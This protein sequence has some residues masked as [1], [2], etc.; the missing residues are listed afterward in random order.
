MSSNVVPL[1]LQGTSDISKISTDLKSV[2]T[3]S[4]NAAT[5]L[6]SATTELDK[7]SKTAQTF[8][9]KLKSF[10]SNFGQLTASVAGLGGSVLNLSRQY[11]DLG[12]SQIKVDQK[13]LKL[14]KSTE[15]VKTA[16]AKLQDLIRKGIKSGAAYEQAQLDVTQALEQET[17]AQTLLGEAV[18]DQQRAQENFWIGLVPTITTAGGTIMGIL[19]NMSGMKGFGG[20]KSA[21]ESATVAIGGGGGKGGG[22]GAGLL[23]ALGMI[24]GGTLA[25]ITGGAAG[26]GLILGQAEQA[27][28]GAAASGLFADPLKDYNKNLKQTEIFMKA[29]NATAFEMLFTFEAVRQKFLATNPV[30][31]STGQILVNMKSQ[32]SDLGPAFAETSAQW[33]GHMANYLKAGESLE[34]IRTRLS[35]AGIKEADGLKIITQ[36]YDIYNTS[37]TQAG[38]ATDSYAS[39]AQFLNANLQPMGPLFDQMTNSLTQAN[40]SLAASGSGLSNLQAGLNAGTA[41]GAA[42]V[43]Q[44]EK[45]IATD[46]A[47]QVSLFETA[48]AMGIAVANEDDSVAILELLIQRTQAMEQGN[49][50]LAESLNAL[51]KKQGQANQVFGERGGAAPAT[52][53]TGRQPQGRHLAGPRNP[54][55]SLRSDYQRA[56]TGIMSGFGMRQTG[57]NAPLK[58]KKKRGQY[59][60]DEIFSQPTWVLAGET[61]QERVRVDTLKG[62]RRPGSGSG[63][64]GTFRLII[65]PPEFARFMRLV[66]NDDQGVMK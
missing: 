44:S 61:D 64:G 15:A 27:R 13:Q 33:A 31:D 41:A 48:K 40:A 58:R 22:K 20:L 52:Y 4:K 54:N 50:D 9:Q 59:G 43:A 17:L 66:V 55:Y 19:Q 65:D 3:E 56:Q 29:T 35:N 62:R 57:K 37:L 11:A 8:G 10:G 39:K 63:G 14:S 7:G 53:R 24:G 32:V 47:F 42:W 60:M 45:Q 5:G 25:G 30:L 46:S 28:A 16:Q 26:A 34:Q 36:A 38:A 18:E 23:G 49:Y 21:V 1:K 6:K 51:I 12:D 2:A